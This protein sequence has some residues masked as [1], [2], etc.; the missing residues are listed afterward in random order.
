MPESMTTIESILPD[1]DTGKQ[2]RTS[3]VSTDHHG[4][5]KVI[6]GTNSRQSS[7][8]YVIAV[9]I[10]SGGIPK[11]AISEA[12]VSRAGLIGDGHNHAKHIRPERA[13]SLLDHELMQQLI[14]EGYSL[15]PGATG[16]NLTVNG[17]H[18]QKLDSGTLLKIGEVILRLEQPRKPCYVLDSI[19]PRLKEAIV[20]RCGYM[21]SVQNEGLIRP[22][23]TVELDVRL[24]N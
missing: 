10:S 8:G 24:R 13:I 20:G 7:Q 2:P 3:E 19:D 9:N 21:A 14:Q 5:A 18:V 16:E 17:L 1:V 4:P 15:F 23:M 11:N 12:Y 22:G 6:W